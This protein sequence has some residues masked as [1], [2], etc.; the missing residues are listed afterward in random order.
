VNTFD[1]KKTLKLIKN[2]KD[3]I[4]HSKG[5]FYGVCIKISLKGRHIGVLMLMRRE[6]TAEWEFVMTERL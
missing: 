3:N 2:K 1:K 5:I 6:S 4:I